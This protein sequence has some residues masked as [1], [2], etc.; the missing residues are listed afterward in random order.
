MLIRYT[1]IKPTTH[2]HSFYISIF[3]RFFSWTSWRQ[4]ILG[5]FRWDHSLHRSQSIQSTF[6]LFPGGSSSKQI[7]HISSRFGSF[8][9]LCIHDCFLVFVNGSHTWRSTLSSSSSDSLYMI[10]FVLIDQGCFAFD[11]ICFL[12][13]LFSQWQKI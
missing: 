8:S 1:Y 7:M 10:N 4:C 11:K 5:H 9:Q 6:L 13:R 12:Q 3:F 2:H